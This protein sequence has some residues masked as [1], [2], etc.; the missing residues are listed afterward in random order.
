MLYQ[1]TDNKYHLRQVHET[2]TDGNNDIMKKLANKFRTLGLVLGFSLLA[3]SQPAAASGDIGEHVNH[4]K[5]NLD[6]YTEEVN[7]LIG[8]IDNMV[9]TYASKGVKAANTGQ[10]VDHWEAVD[11]H[12]AIEVNYVPIY[13]SI[14]QGLFGVKG[15]IDAQKPMAEVKQEQAKLEQALWQ[16]LGAVKLASQYQE[17]GLLARVKTTEQAPSSPAETLD[18]VKQR[19]DRVVAKFAEKLSGEATE[20]VH[21]TYLNLFEGVEG[22]LIEQDAKLVQD[23]EKDFNVTLPKALKA[24]SSVDDV[25]AVVTAM[26]Q[27]LDR[28]KSLLKDADKNRKEVF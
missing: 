19:L 15:A 9:E 20:I 8:K 13:A 2:V 23:L 5:G 10:V 24:D 11:F 6:K 27:K 3:L 22:P 28:A 26:H 7:W 18:V 16:A 4:L 14:W 21:E 17:R 12:S 1:L 25:R